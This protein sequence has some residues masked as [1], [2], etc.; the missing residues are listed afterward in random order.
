MRWLAFPRSR[1]PFSA[2][3]VVR[4]PLSEATE[5]C[6]TQ[7]VRI[8]APRHSPLLST[9]GAPVRCVT[10]LGRSNSL[11]FG[12]SDMHVLRDR[13]GLFPSGSAAIC[14]VA[15]RSGERVRAK[16]VHPDLP[17]CDGRGTGVTA[18]RVGGHG[19]KDIGN[20]AG[21]AQCR[22]TGRGCGSGAVSDPMRPMRCPPRGRRAPLRVASRPSRRH[23]DACLVSRRE[24]CSCDR[25]A[26]P[27]HLIP[28]VV[29]ARRAAG[30]LGL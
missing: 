8:G 19:C 7:A 6:H 20:R 13:L 25:A 10:R 11:E 15:P 26:C 16:E 12:D 5:G 4:I 14:Q 21:T 18:R 27:A 1:S 24:Y 22:A 28:H 30:R 3:T 2:W 23:R 17:M 29:A 9:A